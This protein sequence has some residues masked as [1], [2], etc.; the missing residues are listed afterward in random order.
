MIIFAYDHRGI[1]TVPYGTGVTAE[2][3]RDG[4]Q[5]LHRK[6]HKNRPDLLGDGPLILHDNACPQVGKVVIKLLRKY[7]WVVLPHVP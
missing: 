2:Y 4:M 6:M 3:Y 7:E 5:K 1:M